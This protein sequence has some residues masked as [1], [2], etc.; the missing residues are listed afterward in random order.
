MQQSAA[1]TAAIGGAMD[2]SL[3]VDDS[4]LNVDGTLTLTR[5]GGATLAAGGATCQI[6]INNLVHPLT[7]GSLSVSLKTFL[8]DG[9][10]GVDA[11][12]APVALT[13]VAAADMTNPALVLTSSTAGDAVDVVLNFEAQAR[14]PADAKIIV[15]FPVNFLFDEADIGT[16]TVASAAELTGG[17]TFSLAGDGVT[18][19]LARDGLGNVYA[20]GAAVTDLTIN[21]MRN[22]A[23]SS[24]SRPRTSSLP[25]R[26][27]LPAPS[28]SRARSRSSASRSTVCRRASRATWSLTF[29]SPTRCRSTRLSS[30]PF[31]TASPLTTRRPRRPRPSLASMA[32]SSS[33]RR[34]RQTAFPL[35][36][37]ATVPTWCG[38]TRCPTL[39]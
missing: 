30:S 20:K 36:A 23:F 31:P 5:A 27:T 22:R 33:T 25:S 28:C 14:I 34:L 15:T 21:N 9:V 2:G 39:R 29:P 18:A 16:T 19:T 24:L 32:A 12:P 26:S 38:I 11:L 10:T 7:V 4:Q 8:N 17:W 13:G 37:P 3:T 35:R 6:T 1:V